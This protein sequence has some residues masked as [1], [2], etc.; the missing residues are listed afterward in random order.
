MWKCLPRAL[1]PCF[2][3]SFPIALCRRTVSLD[4]YFSVGTLSSAIPSSHMRLLGVRTHPSSSSMPRNASPLTVAPLLSVALY[5]AFDE[6]GCVFASSFCA[7]LVN[8]RGPAGISCPVFSAAVRA[9][10][11]PGAFPSSYSL[12]FLAQG[13]HASPSLLANTSS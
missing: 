13:F 8:D 10:R 9:A 12:V 2:E 1:F 7:Q 5:P 4:S 6:V 3:L 11:N